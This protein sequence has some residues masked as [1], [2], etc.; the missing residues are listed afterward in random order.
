MGVKKNNKQNLQIWNEMKPNQP[1]KRKLEFRIVLCSENQTKQN[2]T[3]A[4]IFANITQQTGRQAGKTK[5]SIEKW[6]N[7]NRVFFRCCC[8][9]LLFVWQFQRIIT[10][11][12]IITWINLPK[13]NYS[14][15]S[16]SVSRIWWPNWKKKL[17]KRTESVKGNTTKFFFVFVF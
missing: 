5:N 11:Q 3:N 6:S 17:K 15:F 1:E 12:L 10:S 7:S 8:C 16:F 4:F 9:L 14:R 2:K 13:K